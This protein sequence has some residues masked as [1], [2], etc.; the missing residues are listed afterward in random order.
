MGRNSRVPLG[1]QW[2]SSVWKDA[3]TLGDKK[4][5]RTHRI[6]EEDT[7][8]EKARNLQ[9]IAVTCS[10]INWLLNLSELSES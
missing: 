6:E 2:I 8:G 1:A 7:P 4:R 10:A 5:A 3:E 9:R